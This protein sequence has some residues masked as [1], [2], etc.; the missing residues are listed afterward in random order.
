[1]WNEL[2][3][4]GLW[5][6]VDQKAHFE[7]HDLTSRTIESIGPALRAGGPSPA[8]EAW[9]PEFLAHV[10]RSGAAADFL[11]TQTYGVQGGFLDE[12]GKSDTKLDPSPNA[13][14]GDVRQIWEQILASPFPLAY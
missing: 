3:F 10:R 9:V 12:E 2:N 1:M 14:I 11:T 13:I 6:S 4:S 5:E 7:L 8:G